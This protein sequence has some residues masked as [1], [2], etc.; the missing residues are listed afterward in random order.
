[1]QKKKKTS[2]NSGT[3][4]FY[5]QLKGLNPLIFTLKGL[6]YITGKKSVV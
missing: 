6:I 5:V 4:K 3:G 1:M 2:V